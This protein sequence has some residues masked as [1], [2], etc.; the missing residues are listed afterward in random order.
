MKIVSYNIRDLGGR[1]KKKE[2]TETARIKKKEIR[3]TVCIQETKL[4]RVDRR[5]CSL[6]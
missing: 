5:M 2:I 3:E 6:L 4:E 1:I